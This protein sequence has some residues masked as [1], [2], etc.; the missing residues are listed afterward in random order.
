L[1]GE[2]DARRRL[3]D[4]IYTPLRKAGAPLLD[5]AG[6]YLDFGASLET[7]AKA[8]YLHPNTVRYRLRKA[9]DVCGLDP[10][11]HRDRL[12]LHVALILGRLDRS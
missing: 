9:A 2:Q 8:L 5:T 11:D 1:A 10:A 7:T 12:T 4:E 3:I 6:A